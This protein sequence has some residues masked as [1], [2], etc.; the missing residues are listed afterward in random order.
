MVGCI[1]MTIILYTTV[2]MTKMC[3]VYY[4][5]TSFTYMHRTPERNV[6]KIEYLTK[7]LSSLLSTTST[8]DTKAGNNDEKGNYP[9]RK[10]RQTNS[11][12]AA[13]SCHFRQQWQAH[14][15]KN[16]QVFHIAT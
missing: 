14:I 13:T 5:P 6:Q 11:S 8:T 1:Y 4:I 3:S 10:P 15:L 2:Y 9:L 12:N 16:L 7:L